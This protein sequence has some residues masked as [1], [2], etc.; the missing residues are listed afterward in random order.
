MNQTV[1]RCVLHSA[2]QTSRKP[3]HEQPSPGVSVEEGAS[4]EVVHD[5]QLAPGEL[6][7]LKGS[8][9]AAVS[10]QSLARTDPFH[11][12]DSKYAVDFVDSRA[13]EF[14]RTLTLTAC[15]L[16]AWQTH[17]SDWSSNACESSGYVNAVSGMTGSST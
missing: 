3:A 17:A 6:T 5:E 1:W 14:Y 10:T 12:Y 7:L 2:E 4:Y 15:H 11:V 13:T 16:I 8:P 9:P